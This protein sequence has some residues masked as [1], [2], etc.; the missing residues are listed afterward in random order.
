[1]IRNAHWYRNCGMLSCVAHF[2]VLQGSRDQMSLC[3][4]ARATSEAEKVPSFYGIVK[5]EQLVAKS[6]ALEDVK[7]GSYFLA[8]KEA[9]NIISNLPCVQIVPLLATIAFV[10]DCCGD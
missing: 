5:A 2:E 6:R 9:S 8:F 10:Y 3:R 7:L 1:V 4:G